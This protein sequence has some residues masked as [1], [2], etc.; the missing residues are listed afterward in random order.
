MFRNALIFCLILLSY[1]FTTSLITF[2]FSHFQVK[3]YL[4]RRRGLFI[5]AL[6]DAPSFFE[7]YPHRYAAHFLR[8]FASNVKRQFFL[9]TAVL[10]V[11]IH[12]ILVYIAHVAYKTPD[13]CFNYSERR[14]FQFITHDTNQ[15]CKQLVQVKDLFMFS[16]AETSCSY[17]K[18]K[19]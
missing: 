7:K 16:H 14:F 11:K 15:D 17:L 19:T 18:Q 9:L 4:K 5:D 1:D 6:A 13:F 8:W 2:W 10:V 3:I 12:C